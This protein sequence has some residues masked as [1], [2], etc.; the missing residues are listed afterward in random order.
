MSKRPSREAA[1]EAVKTLIA[2]IGDDPERE[3]LIETPARVVKSY[4][5]IF[6][7]Y[8][9]DPKEILEKHKKSA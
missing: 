9:Q 4:D 6:K 8:H 1:L 7:G 2:F 5:E 3:G